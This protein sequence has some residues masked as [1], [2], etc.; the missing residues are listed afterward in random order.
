MKR[1]LALPILLYSLSVPVF[2]QIVCVGQC[3]FS[4]TCEAERAPAN[5]IL[6]SGRIVLGQIVDP[7]GAAFDARYQVQLREVRTGKILVAKALDNQGRFDLGNTGAG[8]YRLIVVRM[9]NGVAKRFGFDQ[10][11]HVYCV[12]EK[13]CE[14]RIVLPIGTTDR[15]ENF[16]SPK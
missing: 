14:T 8:Q 12:G 13:V 6:S 11:S 15:P 3:D 16:C 10:P 9:E 5:F 2:G 4:G 7:S 1:L